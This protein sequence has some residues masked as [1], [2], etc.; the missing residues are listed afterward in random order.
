MPSYE[1]RSV[2][3]RAA[4]I[5]EGAGRPA[6]ELAD[7]VASTAAAFAAA[8]AA[9][10]PAAWAHLVTWTTGQQT[11]AEEIVRSRLGEVLIHHV[12]LNTGYAPGSWPAVFVAGMLPLAARALGENP[13]VPMAIRLTATDTGRTYQIGANTAEGGAVSGAATD[14]LAWLLGRSAG[15]YLAWDGVAELPRLPSPWAV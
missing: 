1:Y 12:D 8:A 11:P 10:P 14:L 6:A 13:Q 9:V 7:D 2:T 15:A 3:A 5:E 4:A